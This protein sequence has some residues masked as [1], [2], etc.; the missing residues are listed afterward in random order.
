MSWALPLARFIHDA[1]L[2]LLF[3]GLLFPLYAFPR[4]RRMTPANLRTA[5]RI[6]AWVAAISAA[7]VFALGVGGM[8]GSLASAADPAL[9]RDT[10]LGGAFGWLFLSRE[11]AIVLC[12]LALMRRKPGAAPVWL[13]GAA[14]AA[15]ALT[16]H[17]QEG[18]GWPKAVHGVLD[19]LHLLCAG[20]WLGALPWLGVLLTSGRALDEAMG[21]V[22][23]F[24]AVATLAV[25]VLLLTGAGATLLL[26]A[27]PLALWS[28]L[29]G[30]LLVLKAI[31][32][33]AMIGLAVH[34]R[35]RLSP[36][37]ERGDAQAAARLRRNA[38]LELAFGMVI[39][40][41]V[42]WLGTLPFEPGD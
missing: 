41:L 6:E 42:G 34:N 30:R 32:A 23:R 10:A 21:A 8:A 3:G 20:L 1:A 25:G 2:I 18:A 35:W 27:S 5:F 13:S 38:G 14:L 29:W 15:L 36:G 11:A 26:V 40:A 39:L 12:A 28:T 22:R 16:G 4:E 33:A 17:A 7:A 37:A 9:L 19:A 24:S 31:L